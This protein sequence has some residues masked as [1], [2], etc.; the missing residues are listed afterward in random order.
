MSR[1]MVDLVG[2]ACEGTETADGQPLARGLSSLM[3][4]FAAN[5]DELGMDRQT[6]RMKARLN[7]FLRRLAL[8]M[9]RAV[10]DLIPASEAG[11]GEG[12][13]EDRAGDR[14]GDGSKGSS[15]GTSSLSTARNLAKH[16]SPRSE[17]VVGWRVLVFLR[18]LLAAG[19]VAGH[20]VAVLA[21]PLA[22]AVCAIVAGSLAGA[23]AANETGDVGRG[24]GSGVVGGGG[25]EG[26]DEGG[27]GEGGSGTD[28][29]Q[30]LSLLCTIF[31][32]MAEHDAGGSVFGELVRTGTFGPL[33]AAAL[34][35]P[36]GRAMDVLGVV[37]GLGPIGTIGTLGT[38][39]TKAA[40]K[41]AEDAAEDASTGGVGQRGVASFQ[42]N[43]WTESDSLAAKYVRDGGGVWDGVG[44]VGGKSDSEG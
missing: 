28:R 31:Q 30:I 10:D 32:R 33:C 1:E 11:E 9:S 34:R 22:S 17:S 13:V 15:D 44:G 14:E 4:L 39:G 35:D 26:G 24:G 37:V 19:P 3:T 36:L 21:P 25:K 40:G 18:D 20:A 16:F 12:S 27:D 5:P 6:D 7:D 43:H 2:L 42:M 23:V 38:I 29:V 41:S 8:C